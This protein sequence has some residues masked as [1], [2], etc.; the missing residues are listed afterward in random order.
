MS[1][2]QYPDGIN[3]DPLSALN[4][5][6]GK[7]I[8]ILSTADLGIEAPTEAKDMGINL[9]VIPFIDTSRIQDEYISVRVNELASKPAVVVFTSQHAVMAVGEILKESPADW[10]IYCL[11]KKTESA[12]NQ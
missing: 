10:L 3:Y 1:Q 7:A 5:G 4:A 11:G 2:E 12:V 9:D 8:T 6:R